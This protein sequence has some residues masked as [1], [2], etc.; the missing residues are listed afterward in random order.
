M[1]YGLFLGNGADALPTRL[2]T[3][4]AFLPV[5]ASA[6]QPDDMAIFSASGSTDAGAH[7]V[8]LYFSPA[9]SAFANHWWR[10]ALRETASRKP[11]SRDRQFS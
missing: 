7:E 11:R 1:W 6:G 10:S 3:Q 5:F 4:T 2:Q 9:A 8:T